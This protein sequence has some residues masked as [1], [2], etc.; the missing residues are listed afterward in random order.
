MK[1]IV[2]VNNW[3]EYFTHVISKV[4]GKQ[5]TFVELGFG[6]DE[7]AKKIIELM[8]KN[9]LDKRD[10]WLFDSFKG[11]PEPTKEDIGPGSRC[12]GP[13]S[14]GMWNVAK[15]P[16]LALDEAISTT[17]HVIEGFV[18]DTLPQSYNGGDIAVLHLDVDLYS[19]YKTGLNSLFDRVIDGGVI[20]FDEYK[21]PLQI[22]GYP[23]AAKAVDEFFE[24]RNI[25]PDI[26]LGQFPN[27]MT[28]KFYM[29]KTNQN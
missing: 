14:K 1:K 17:V 19:A 7:S 15:A 10:I 12:T 9:I 21:S 3:Q 24:Q 29:I 25:K 18:E 11:F 6:H 5:G 16:A 23:G 26:E 2:S 13:E 28:Q 22:V 20:L 27:K 8:N 4:N